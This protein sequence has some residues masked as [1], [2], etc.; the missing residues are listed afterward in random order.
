MA[1]TSTTKAKAANIPTVATVVTPGEIQDLQQTFKVNSD[2][3]EEEIQRMNGMPGVRL[4]FDYVHFRKL[5]DDFIATLSA[6]NQKAYWL[7]FAEFD[8]RDR[9]SNVALHSIGVDPIMKI[10][11]RPR[12]RNNPLVRD[13]DFVSKLL[14]GWYVT[15][16]VQGGEG[17]FNLALEA[18]FKVIRHPLD[19]EEEKAKSPLDWS[20]EIWKIPDGVA[21]PT[22]GEGI[23]NVM[24]VIR[25]QIWDDNLKA[26]SM[27][28]HNA[29]AQNKKQFFEG[30]ENI[31]RDMLGGKEKV[32][33]SD[34]DEVRE[35]E[36]Y[37]HRE[38]RTGS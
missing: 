16:R 21:D 2:V 5:S 35:E 32:I 33:L 38:K 8:D 1:K 27:A 37:D 15:W 3:G 4:E 24:V 13:G 23:Y 19:K 30:A 28:S 17:D 26:Q 34:L 10:L 31:S 18:G 36:Y 22:S 14:P 25:Q 12:G 11:D 9:R 7:A 20:G 6:K 29:Y